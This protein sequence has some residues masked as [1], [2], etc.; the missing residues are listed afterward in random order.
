MFINPKNIF[1]A[2]PK[3]L[4]VKAKGI[5]FCVKYDKM[6]SCIVWIQKGECNAFNDVK[7][8][9]THEKYELVSFMDVGHYGY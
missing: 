4:F 7:T 8:R 5:F 3:I 9:K 1:C 2:Y 6:D